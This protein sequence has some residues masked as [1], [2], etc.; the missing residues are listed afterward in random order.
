MRTGFVYLHKEEAPK[1]D[2]VGDAKFH[3]CG[4]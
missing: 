4:I 3:N 2:E 1:Y